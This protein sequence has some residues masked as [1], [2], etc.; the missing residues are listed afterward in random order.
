MDNLGVHF[1]LTRSLEKGVGRIAS[2][3]W[4][5]IWFFY[6]SCDGGDKLHL[7]VNRMGDRFG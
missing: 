1:P 6:L 4:G 7:K 2:G 3:E 5:F